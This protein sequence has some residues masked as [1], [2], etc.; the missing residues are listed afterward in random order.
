[1]IDWPKQLINDIARRR[2]VIMIGSGI[3]KNSVGIAGAKPPTWGEFMSDAL[4]Q[5]PPKSRHIQN[6]LKSG[7]YLS[8]CEWIKK[9]MDERW[10]P[11]LVE[12]FLTPEYKPN[13]LHEFIFSLDTSI[14]VTPNFDKIFDN[15]VTERTHGTTIVKAYYD[16]DVQQ[17]IRAG[18]PVILKLHGTI[19]APDRMIFGR[20]DYASARINNAAFYQLIDALLLTNTFLMLGCGLSDPDFQLMFENF[21]YRFP[22]SQPHYMAYA[23]ASHNEIETLVRDTRKLKILKYSKAHNHKEL[24]QSL[25]DLVNQVEKERSEISAN[26]SW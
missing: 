26:S 5:V 7:D 25:E 17:L 3:S 16:D 8:A 9:R 6:A 4:D 10:N 24:E 21:S 23:D 2:A 19:D 18:K 15:Y 1:V 20:S 12:K 13:K 22:N 14:Y 11:Y